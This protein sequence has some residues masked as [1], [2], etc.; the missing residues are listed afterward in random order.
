M[1]VRHRAVDPQAFFV[2]DYGRMRTVAV[3]PDGTLW[4]TTSNRD[5]RGTPR[6][7]DDRILR[8]EP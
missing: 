2:G 1:A 8:I 3:A 7:G 4:L 5:E 6:E